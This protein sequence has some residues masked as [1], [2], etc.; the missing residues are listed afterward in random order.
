MDQKD[1]ATA[2]TGYGLKGDR[3]AD[4]RSH[5]QVLLMDKEILDSLGL[6]PGIIRENIT[7]SGLDIH[8]LPYGQHLR[9]GD[10]VVLEITEHCE[11]CTRMDE[12]RPGLRVT[13]DMRRGMLARVVQGGEIKI[14]DAVRSE[15]AS[16]ST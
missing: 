15:V 14:G 16:H 4:P 10:E 1:R 6:E 12:I 11:P 7:V 13:L 2:I 3:H 8:N 5:R 9:L